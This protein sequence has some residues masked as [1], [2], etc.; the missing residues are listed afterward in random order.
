MKK[1]NLWCLTITLAFSLPLI[2]EEKKEEVK[3]AEAA[4]PIGSF[5]VDN[6]IVSD[7]VFRGADIQQN[8]FVQENKKFGA[9][10]KSFAYQPSLTWNT[11]VVGLSVNLWGSFALTHRADRDVDSAIQSGPGASDIIAGNCAASGCD[12]A[13]IN[14]TVGTAGVAPLTSGLAGNLNTD[15]SLKLPGQY[16]E[17]NGLKRV[18]EL[19]VT[20][21]YTSV[22]SIGKITTGFIHYSLANPVA[23]P[24]QFAGANYYSTEIYVGC[25]FPQIPQILFKLNSDIVNSFQ[26]WSAAY[27]D[28]KA[29]SESVNLVYG[30][31]A[32]YNTR[33]NIQ[34]WQDVTG[35]LGVA[36]GGFTA[37]FNFAYRPNLKIME[38]VTASGDPNTKVAL[39]LNGGSTMYDGM[40]ADPSQTN[41]LAH[42]IFNNAV[43]ARVSAGGI[44]YTY[45]PRQKMP[46][47]LYWINFGYA[48]SI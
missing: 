34:G 31:S 5:T 39:A 44:P 10:N 11:P 17:Q 20:I 40:V 35:K 42:R 22:T 38:N 25:A 23:R 8:Y 45:T 29:I 26:Y 36:I 18:D 48:I 4:L 28:T 15:G 37:G 24:A 46:A 19:D 9:W 27:S 6:Q 13:A 3:S 41:D 47:V 1:I 33:N 12:V 30:I 2:A 43:G 21:D 7:Y 32:G 16:R 14:S